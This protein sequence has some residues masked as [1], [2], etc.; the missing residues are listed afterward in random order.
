MLRNGLLLLACIFASWHLAQGG[1]I[2]AKAWLA[3]QLLERAWEQ[4]L[5]TGAALRPWPWADT[6]AVA[7]LQVPRLGIDQIVLAGASG[8]SLAFGPGHLPSSASPGTGGN[9]VLAGHRDTHFRF[10]SELREQ[11][12]IHLV[13][14]G[15]PDRS[16]TVTALG[17]VDESQTW[18]LADNGVSSLTLV[19]CYP[20]ATVRPGGPLRYVVRAVETI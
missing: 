12:R 13:V 14:P 11:D 6:Q 8:R 3:Q 1:Y 4:A 18:V 10:L 15:G 19:T 17:V 20:F 16:Y 9:T 5:V 2:H 7:R